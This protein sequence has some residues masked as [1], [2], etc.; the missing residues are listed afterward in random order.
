MT[1]FCL[2]IL[3]CLDSDTGLD[4]FVAFEEV[5]YLARRYRCDMV[6]LA[7]D[8]FHENRPSRRTLYKTM[9]ILRRYTMG[10]NPVQVQIL[11]NPQPIN[12]LN[13]HVRFCPFLSC[14]HENLS[15]FSL[16]GIFD[17]CQWTYQSLGFMATTMIRVSVLAKRRFGSNDYLILTL[18]YVNHSS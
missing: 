7:G 12:Y 3:R 9:D 6:L 18:A 4:S 10:D 16:A 14:L 2:E 17:R 8:L 11:G 15:C 13:P 5:L 1:F